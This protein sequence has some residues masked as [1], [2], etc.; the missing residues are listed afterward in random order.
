M[1]IRAG[2]GTREL[3]VTSSPC[4]GTRRRQMGSPPVRSRSPDL[5]GTWQ[6]CDQTSGCRVRLRMTTTPRS[7]FRLLAAL[8][9]AATAACASNDTT[10]S[11]LGATQLNISADTVKG[12]GNL[13]ELQQRR[14]AW[15]ARGIDDYR[16][17][18]QIT[19]F[20]GGD[21]RRPVLVEVRDGA[22]SFGAQAAVVVAIESAT[23]SRRTERGVVVIRSRTRL[24]NVWSQH[25][26]LAGGL[27]TAT[28]WSAGS[29]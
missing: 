12:T 6:P 3:A 29:A 16:F 19:C 11:G 24:R 27:A 5:G 28:G 2:H 13:S 1:T 8:S 9:I 14:A 15:L 7:V 25:C 22:V 18:L 26:R 23:R 17:Q 10:P 21:I 4:R 20:C